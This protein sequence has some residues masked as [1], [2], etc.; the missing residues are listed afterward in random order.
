MDGEHISESRRRLLKAGLAG[1]GAL[2]VGPSLLTACGGSEGGATAEATTT[3]PVGEMVPDEALLAVARKEGAL[4]LIAVPEGEGSVYQHL[5]TGFRSYSEL[6]VKVDRP[7]ATSA[8]EMSAVA[9]GKGK[10]TQPDV[11]DVGV[12]YAVEGSASGL[13]A[14][15]RPT[16]W[17]DIPSNAKDPGGR[18]V[19]TYYGLVS[20]I[21]ASTFPGDA[22]Q[23]FADL[24]DLPHDKP[25]W[26]SG[27]PRSEVGPDE[28]GKLPSALA[29]GTVWAAALANGGSLDDIGPGI[30]F[31]ADLVSDGIFASEQSLA[32]AS[33][34][35]TGRCP[36]VM[37]LNYD[38][39]AVRNLA[40][41][42]DPSLEFELT[43][44]TDG[45]FPNFYAQGAV[46]GSPHP[47]AAKLWLEY[48]LSDEGSLLFLR[49]GAI[50]IRFP[51]MSERGKVPD[52]LLADLPE[53][54][55]LAAVQ[56]PSQAQVA[57]A[58]EV[59]DA[60]WRSDVVDQ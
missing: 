6:E 44:P 9:E 14:S 23:T 40:S 35:A 45:L 39:G 60:R 42:G 41:A 24:R 28:S 37:L 12:S 8:M 20:F 32:V 54:D 19:S 48:L 21:T 34:V 27:D 3:A 7:G 2:A 10:P 29:F 11:V 33:L 36:V 22:P 59:V 15:Y 5:L 49:G 30:D 43:V 16:A 47:S 31:F 17:D 4:N 18:W 56:I 52:D 53:T 46:E 50:P 25:L 51:I 1:V 26:M 57:K 38:I 55:A 13:L 58:R